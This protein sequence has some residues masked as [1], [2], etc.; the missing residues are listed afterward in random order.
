MP[1]DLRI[2]GVKVGAEN[3]VAVYLCQQTLCQIDSYRKPLDE[4]LSKIM[5]PRDVVGR[6]L[7]IVDKKRGK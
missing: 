4:A 2:I 7:T 6:R 1:Q 5:I 3:R